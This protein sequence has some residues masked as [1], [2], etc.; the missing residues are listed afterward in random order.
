MDDFYKKSKK[1]VKSVRKA[2]VKDYGE[3]PGE[4]EAQLVQLEDMYACY[5]DCADKLRLSGSPIALINDGK[6]ECSSPYFTTM[7]SCIMYMDKIIKSFGLS[8]IARKNLKGAEAKPESN[9]EFIDE[10]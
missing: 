7:R 8:P 2:I 5:L 10:L 4:W 1:Y 9:D 6:T 3:V